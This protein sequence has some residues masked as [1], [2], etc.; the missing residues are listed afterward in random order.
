MSL[1]FVKRTVA[2]AEI[3]FIL[4]LAEMGMSYAEIAK[5]VWGEDCC[6]RNG[7]VKENHISRISYVLRDYDVRVGDYRN[8]RNLHG[9]AVIAA[10][11][12]GDNLLASIRS[13]GEARLAKFA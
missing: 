2:D 7:R 9:K 8:A 12:R 4:N 5:Q 1:T 13:R 6:K 11:K 10:C 3:E